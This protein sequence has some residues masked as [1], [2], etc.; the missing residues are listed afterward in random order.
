[1]RVSTQVRGLGQSLELDFFA[2]RGDTSR[3]GPGPDGGSKDPPYVLFCVFCASA[4]L[5]VARRP[6][7]LHYG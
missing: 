7:G 3:Y 4:V 1:M 5:I 2:E 6:E